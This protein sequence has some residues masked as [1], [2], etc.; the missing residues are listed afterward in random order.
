M[1]TDGAPAA[2][3][4]LDDRYRLV[5]QVGSGGMS[6]VF[7][8]H[9][10]VLQRQVAV[11]MLAPNLSADPVLPRRLLL[12]ARAVAALRHPNITTVFDFGVHR[13]DDG[14]LIPYLVMEMLDGEL[15]SDVLHLGR[16]PWREAVGVCAQLAAALAAAHAAGIVHHDIT[17]ANIMLTSTGVKVL[18]FGISAVVGDTQHGVDGEIVGTAAYLAPERLARGHISAY[19][20]VYAAGLVLYRCLAGRLP[21]AAGTV[22][23]MLHAHAHVQPRRLPPLGLPQAI[24]DTCYQCLARE[25]DHR[26]SA[27][28]LTRMLSRRADRIPATTI[29]IS[30][31][32]PHPSTGDGQTTTLPIGALRPRRHLRS[33]RILASAAALCSIL[34]LGYLL[35]PTGPSRPRTVW[36][37]AQADTTGTAPCSITYSTDHTK[38]HQFDVAMTITNTGPNPIKT[39][40]LQFALPDGE[41]IV[42]S[43]RA[44]TVQLADTQ[45]IRAVQQGQ[46]VTLTGTSALAPG[47]PVWLTLTGR[48]NGNTTRPAAGFAL[49][50]QRC[51]ATLTLSQ[52]MHAVQPP[53]T[54]VTVA[55]STPNRTLPG[56]HKPKALHGGKHSLS[57]ANT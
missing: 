23:E 30:Q 57:H 45:Q 13:A 44:D 31:S 39:W 55:P 49:N 24:E 53:D 42:D 16:M 22:A 25:P 38:D 8:A 14:T 10:E 18:D 52:G 54:T 15:L 4:R 19:A 32:P 51:D 17:P 20:D 46:Q 26:P 21:W 27:A 37:Q 35:Y 56:S 36:A 41:S 2:G 28:E 40:T 47:I 3:L 48:G 29:R 5:K 9:D 11:K 33:R 6:V 7:D 34:A 43:Y 12:E 50:G 1:N